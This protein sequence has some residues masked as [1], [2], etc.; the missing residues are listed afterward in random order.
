MPTISPDLKT[1]G[2]SAIVRISRYIHLKQTGATGSGDLLDLQVSA[3]AMHGIFDKEQQAEDPG[4]TDR[5]S[6]STTLIYQMANSD[7]RTA[8]ADAIFHGIAQVGEGFPRD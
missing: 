1:D 8:Q 6:R 3:E 4:E 5:D 2:I 7:R